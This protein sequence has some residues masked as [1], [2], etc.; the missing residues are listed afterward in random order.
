LNYGPGFTTKKASCEAHSCCF[1]H[2][3]HPAM[4]IFCLE[5]KVLMNSSASKGNSD[6]SLW[7]GACQAH[8]FL[9]YNLPHGRLVQR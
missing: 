4:V 3:G 1:P 2:R 7:L 5:S 6:D 9:V 8:R